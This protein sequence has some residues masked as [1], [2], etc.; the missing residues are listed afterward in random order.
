M[1]IEENFDIESIHIDIPKPK[2]FNILNPNC[3][4]IERVKYDET[5]T[6]F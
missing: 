4:F 1:S 6:N 3:I 5:V 2:S